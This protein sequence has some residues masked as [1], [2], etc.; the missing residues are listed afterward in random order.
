[1][2]QFSPSY[3]TQLDNDADSLSELQASLYRHFIMLLPT[4]VK[5]GQRYRSVTG[6]G[7]DLWLNFLECHKYT[8]FLR[9]THKFIASSDAAEDSPNAH[10][11]IYHDA[12]VAEVTSFSNLQGIRRYSGPW[13]PARH[14]YHRQYKQNRALLKWLE[15][16][17]ELGHSSDSLKLYSANE[18]VT[19]AIGSDAVG[20]VKKIT[21]Y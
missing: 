8:D 6:S 4:D 16:L 21:D 17:H 3:Q 12:R 15:Y 7:P 11:R 20:A 13:L 5:A 2:V 10:I 9:L 19:L 18:K 14:V 1:M